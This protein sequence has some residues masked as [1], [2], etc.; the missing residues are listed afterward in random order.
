MP[1]NPSEHSIARRG[2]I[3]QKGK[4]ERSPFMA[5]P[6]MY[7]DSS[8][9]LKRLREICL[10][11]PECFEKEAWGSCTFRVTGG[12][13]FAMTEN[14]HHGSGRVAVWIKQPAMVQ[15]ILVH[16]DG[17]R[18]FIPPYVGPKGWLGVRLDYK[19]DWNELAELLADGHRLSAPKRLRA[20]L[21]EAEKEGA[22]AP[23]LAANPAAVARSPRRRGRAAESKARPQKTAA[24]RPR[25]KSKPKRPDRSA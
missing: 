8:P 2:G 21:E 20:R 12:S 5:H 13:M 18:F 1:I 25:P 15:E 14:N 23:V 10:A 16:A 17:K 22:P 19:V 7:D 24:R 9:V 11:L 6:R 4:H 3:D